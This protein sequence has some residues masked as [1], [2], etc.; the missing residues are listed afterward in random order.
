MSLSYASDI[1]PLF[2]DNPDIACMDRRGVRLGDSGWMCNL[3]HAQR[4]Y[5][6]LQTGEMPPD[7]A[8]PASRVAVFKR[9]MAE[10]CL[11]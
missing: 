8:W 5:A 2:R 10:G 11:P 6:K 9:W 1:R 3:V 7:G 4:V